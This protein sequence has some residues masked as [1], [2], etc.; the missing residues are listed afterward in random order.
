MVSDV[1]YVITHVRPNLIIAA[2]FYFVIS[3]TQSRI[4]LCLYDKIKKKQKNDVLV[5]VMSN[6]Y[7]I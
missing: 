2:V 4:G 3:S 7:R 1:N 6:V 5:Y